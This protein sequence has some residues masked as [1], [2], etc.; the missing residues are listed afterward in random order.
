MH[1]AFSHRF[2]HS[3]HP[4]VG[5]A[6]CAVFSYGSLYQSGN[7]DLFIASSVFVVP[8]AVFAVGAV[9]SKLRLM[10]RRVKQRRA[11]AKPQADRAASNLTPAAKRAV[12][13]ILLE[14]FLLQHDQL[15][16]EERKSANDARRYV[17]YGYAIGVVSEVRSVFVACAVGSLVAHS[18]AS[19]FLYTADGCGLAA[20][21]AVWGD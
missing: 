9:V 2:A 7:A 20:G 19:C 14:R 6:V 3:S 15:M 10:R 13:R 18:E 21:C 4:P 16:F 11:A 17:C 8:M 12:L 5:V 1:L